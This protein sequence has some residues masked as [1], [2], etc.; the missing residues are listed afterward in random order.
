MHSMVEG[1]S[2]Q[3]WIYEEAPLRQGF[4]LPP[5]RAGEDQWG[6]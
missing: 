5:P 3:R 4:A 2:P 1:G 6:Q